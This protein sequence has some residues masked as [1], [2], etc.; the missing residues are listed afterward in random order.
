MNSPGASGGK[1]GILCCPGSVRGFPKMSEISDKTKRHPEC[2]IPL[3]VNLAVLVLPAAVAPVA[4]L[5]VE[6]LPD[7]ADFCLNDSH[8]LPPFVVLLRNQPQRFLMALDC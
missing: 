4:E 5:V 1:L 6:V 2:R 8:L 3:V 7:V